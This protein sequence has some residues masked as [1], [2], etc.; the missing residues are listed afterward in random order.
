[1][2]R[3]GRAVLTVVGLATFTSFSSSVESNVGSFH[4][5]ATVAAWIG[6]RRTARSRRRSC[7]RGLS[8]RASGTPGPVRLLH[9]TRRIAQQRASRQPADFAAVARTW[10]AG[11]SL[12]VSSNGLGWASRV[13]RDI[14]PTARLEEWAPL[15][16]AWWV[17]RCAYWELSPW[18]RLALQGGIGALLVGGI[19]VILATGPLLLAGMMNLLPAGTTDR[20]LLFGFLLVVWN[21]IIIHSALKRLSD[22]LSDIADR[23]PR[24]ANRTDE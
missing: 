18:K 3:T 20:I 6:A 24:Q 19:V 15:L 22:R 9:A 11:R 17:G 21:L 1:M 5:V 12:R 23:L 2:S 13:S 8:Q 4:T 7:H 10:L 16:F 14:Q